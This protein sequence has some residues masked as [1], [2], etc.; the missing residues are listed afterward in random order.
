MGRT[1]PTNTFTLRRMFEKALIRRFKKLSQLITKVIVEDDVFGLTNTPMVQAS[2][3]RQA[4]NFPRSGDR[5]AAF[6][7]WLNQQ[8]SDG[9][10]EI[11]NMSQIGSG[12]EGAW[13]NMYIT[14]SYKRGVQRARYE[15]NKAGFDV[16]KIGDSGGI[17]AVM[18]APFHMDRVGLLY[19]RV[20]NELKGITD[21]MSIQMNKVLA[22]GMI[23]GDGPRTLARKMNAVIK[24]GGADLSMTDTLGRFIPAERRARMLAQTEMIRAHHIATV[25]EYK[26]WGTVGVKVQA[27]WSTSGDDRVCE[28]C[29]SLEGKVY[30]LD[31]IENLIPLH[32]NCRCLALPTMP[33]KNVEEQDLKK[34][35]T[36]SDS[37]PKDLLNVDPV[38]HNEI[39]QI[40]NNPKAL[41]QEDEWLEQLY[42]IQNFNKLPTMVD[43]LDGIKGTRMYRGVSERDQM[44]Q[45]MTK[46][47]VFAGEGIYGHGS[48]FTTLQSEAKGYGSNLMSAVLPKDAKVIT[49]NDLLKKQ[50]DFIN[51][52]ID[53]MS[54]GLQ[55]GE[56][57]KSDMIYWQRYLEMVQDPGRFATMSGYDAIWVQSGNNSIGDYYIIQ[58]RGKLIMKSI[59]KQ[60]TVKPK[61]EIISKTEKILRTKE[62]SIQGLSKEQGLLYDQQGKLLLSK[63]GTGTNVK[64][65]ELEG[66]L[67]KGNILTHN[68]PVG[69]RGWAGSFS[70]DDINVLK[71]YKLSQMRATV[72]KSMYEKAGTYIATMTPEGN[73]VSEI[74]F[75]MKMKRI[76][77]A[78]RQEMTALVRAGKMSVLKANSTIMKTFWTKFANETKYID[79]KFIPH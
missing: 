44:I 31:E 15:M 17:N 5:V 62:K 67:F 72:G 42:S 66:E 57:A 2:P 46:D 71:K 38:K 40:L 60:K 45:F 68:H 76:L 26:N 41:T 14:D 18:N 56:I 19:T 77:D 34:T 64:W 3:G 53:K 39:R 22:Q 1:D 29:R 74:V 49:Y 78:T 37:M 50:T 24:G 9:V 32:P 75:N 23:D 47:K 79:F 58:N 70:F 12:V 48:Y 73:A 33:E 20:F 25:Q 7:Q 61:K 28:Q 63:S 36:L 27:E 43:D 30:T 16:P 51:S 11:G 8:V 65:T 69:T 35:K 6:M 59:K 13:T 4:F 54:S 52:V 55:S 21:T 10:L